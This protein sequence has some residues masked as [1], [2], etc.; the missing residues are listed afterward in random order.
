MKMRGGQSPFWFTNPWAAGREIEGIT[1][2]FSW[3]L[4]RGVLGD[5]VA[6][7]AVWASKSALVMIVLD[8]K[9]S[10]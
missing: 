5:E 1:T 8:G 9:G 4:R 2:L 10:K 3:K 6:K 7:R